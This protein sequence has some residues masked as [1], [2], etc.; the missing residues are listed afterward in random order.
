MVSGKT[1]QYAPIDRADMMAI[2]S[3]MDRERKAKRFLIPRRLHIW[4]SGTD[5]ADRRFSSRH[6]YHAVRGR[7]TLHQIEGL[8]GQPPA[9]GDPG[10]LASHWWEGRPRPKKRYTLGVIPHY[11]DKNHPG[12]NCLKAAANICFI[13]VFWPV[14]EILRTIQEC[15]FVLS[16]S[17]HGLIISDAFDIPNRRMR[18]SSG[19]ISDYKFEDYYSAFDIPSP[20]AIT[21]EEITRL[22]L[23]SPDTWIGVYARPGRDSICDALINSFPTL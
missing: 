13:D 8:T 9:L 16:S 5:A 22:N 18:L 23:R 20:D 14:E 2:G 3:I 19:L 12:L 1:V 21:A 17:M 11:V 7:K 6:Y 10:L 4:G 15:E